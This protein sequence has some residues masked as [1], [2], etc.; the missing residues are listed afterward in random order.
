MRARAHTHTDSVEFCLL[1]SAY[2]A[3]GVEGGVGGGYIELNSRHVDLVQ[4][5]VLLLVGQNKLSNLLTQ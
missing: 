3:N 1:S 4:F 2:N 5:I